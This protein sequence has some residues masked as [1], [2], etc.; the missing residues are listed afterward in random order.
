MEKGK[1]ELIDNGLLAFM[2]LQRDTYYFP[3]RGS[4]G[5]AFH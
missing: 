2:F 4:F 1:A 5:N 3:D